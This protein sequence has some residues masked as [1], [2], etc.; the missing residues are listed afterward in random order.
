M[1]RAI[2]G[3]WGE[4]M[5]DDLTWD[6]K[7]L[8]SRGITDPKRVGIMGGSYGGYAALVGVTSTQTSM[9]RRWRSMPRT[10]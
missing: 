7:Y 5:Q 3:Q 9:R 6:V 8:I 1:R 2:A 4:R 10:T